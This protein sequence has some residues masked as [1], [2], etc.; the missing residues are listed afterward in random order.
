MATLEFVLVYV[1]APSVADEGITAHHMIF[2]RI[3]ERWPHRR[4][5]RWPILEVVWHC[6]C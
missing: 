5:L 6:D 3:L 2:L 1:L 4:R